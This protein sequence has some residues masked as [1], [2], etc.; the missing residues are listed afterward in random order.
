MG[1][2]LEI[3]PKLLNPE[4][5]TYSWLINGEEYSNERT[6]SYKVEKPCRANL[7]CII[8]NEYGKVEMNTSFNSNHDFSKGFLYIDDT[9]NFY[10]TEKKVKYEDCYSSLNA[11][12]S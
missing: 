12:K 11:G 8:S 7:T 9:F 3:T 10:D 2:T 4:N 6:F 5:T 1:E